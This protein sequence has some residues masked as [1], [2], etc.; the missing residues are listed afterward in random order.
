[1]NA[2]LPRTG[3]P[4]AAPAAA[5]LDATPARAARWAPMALPL[6]FALALLLQVALSARLP[7]PWKIDPSPGVPPGALALRLASLGEDRV[8]AYATTLY[9]QSFDAQAGALLPLRDADLRSVLAWLERAHEMDPRSGYPA[10]LASFDYAE[11]AAV[12]DARRGGDPVAPRLLD[13]ASTSFD[14]APAAQWPWLAHAAWVARYT[15]H[16]DARALRFARQLRDAP[17][18]VP[19]PRW[20]RELDTYVLARASRAEAGQA[21]LGGYAAGSALHGEDFVGRLAERLS[22][23]GAQGLPG[24]GPRPAPGTFVGK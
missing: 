11:V 14:A 23:E 22:G 19:I 1:M 16:D 17:A 8:A 2:S 24:D 3:P 6:L 5:R 15:L 9:V 10:M 12:V 7:N 21:L 4:D 20:A 18:S 13:L